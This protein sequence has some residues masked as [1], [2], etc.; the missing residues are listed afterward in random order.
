HRALPSSP[1]WAE[2]EWGEGAAAAQRPLRSRPGRPRLLSVA[3]YSCPHAHRALERG[4][5]GR[6][7]GGKGGGSAREKG[8][9]RGSRRG[10]RPAV[11]RQG[12]PRRLLAMGLQPRRATGFCPPAGR[13]AALPGARTAAAWARSE[14]PEGAPGRTTSR[15]PILPASAASPVAARAQ[16][17]KPPQA[18]TPKKA[19]PRPVEDK[20][21]RKARG[22]PP[23]RAGPLSS[24]WPC[25]SLQR[26]PPDEQGGRLQPAAPQPRGRPGA[27]GASSRSCESLGGAE[28]EAALRFSLSLPPEAVRLLQ[29]RSQERQ[30]GQLAPS[31]GGR[32][33][34]AWRGVGA[35]GSDLRALLK[36]SLLNDR[37]RYDDEEYEEEEEAAGAG[38]AVDEG[39]VRKCTEWLRGVESAASRDRSDRLGTLPHLGTL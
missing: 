20:A 38:A 37:H 14:E 28:G 9:G 4:V 31:P 8:S 3:P 15:P 25:S 2:R 36:I 29:R 32:P 22:A 6:A 39:L 11:C 30:R 7:K 1:L 19:A 33:A 34:P 17:K 24:S 13:C 21:A 18:T 10:S 35:G 27:P 23:E 16:P 12:S 26:R 5:P